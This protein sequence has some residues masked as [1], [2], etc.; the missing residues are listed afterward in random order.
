[1]LDGSPL[2]EDRAEWERT[3]HLRVDTTLP[4]ARDKQ[5]MQDEAYSRRLG[6]AP[7]PNGWA[8][9]VRVDWIHPVEPEVEPEV[10]TVGAS[11]WTSWGV[12]AHPAWATW[13]PPSP[14]AA[15][16]P[17][18]TAVSAAS[19]PDAASPPAVLAVPAVPIASPPAAASE[20][21]RAPSPET[22]AGWSPFREWDSSTTGHAYIA[23]SNSWSA[24]DMS[25][26]ATPRRV[27]TPPNPSTSAPPSSPPLAI[28]TRREYD[29]EI[30]ARAKAEYRGLLEACNAARCT[31]SA[32]CST[33]VQHPA[34]GLFLLG[35]A[36]VDA[37]LTDDCDTDDGSV[38]AGFSRTPSPSGMYSTVHF[39]GSDISADFN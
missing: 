34:A 21:P 8:T 19:P 17:A 15:S 25:P 14:P 35:E 11:G 10:E 28:T 22:S 32:P 9:S 5:R 29:H 12:S 26:V 24:A 27:A 4:T 7:P 6:L 31:A 33:C 20:I 3:R 39:P 16:P 23:G 37:S 2:E 1:M 30:I 38:Y 13:N 36:S 18:V